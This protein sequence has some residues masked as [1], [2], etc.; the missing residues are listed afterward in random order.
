MVFFTHIQYV[1]PPIGL[2]TVQN[3]CTEQFIQIIY[4]VQLEVSELLP[5]PLL[6]L[7]TFKKELSEITYRMKTHNFK[8]N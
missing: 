4:C 6:P 3:L 1:Y 8:D 2:K 7:H 5:L